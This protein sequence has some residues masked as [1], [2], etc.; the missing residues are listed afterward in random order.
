MSVKNRIW[1]AKDHEECTKTILLLLQL[2]IH[3]NTSVCCIINSGRVVHVSG[4]VV[5]YS[6][7]IMDLVIGSEKPSRH[8][9]NYNTKYPG[10]RP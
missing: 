3:K 4:K 1:K 9:T 10:R 7:A 5:P 6:A 8:V 2:R